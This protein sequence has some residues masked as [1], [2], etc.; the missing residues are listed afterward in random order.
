MESALWQLG[1]DRR[2]SEVVK[3]ERNGLVRIRDWEAPDAGC[4]AIEIMRHAGS[5]LSS[6]NYG[7]ELYIQPPEKTT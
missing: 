2:L 5:F 3:R 1:P 4:Y 7:I 6:W